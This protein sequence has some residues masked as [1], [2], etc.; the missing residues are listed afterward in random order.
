[1]ST[2]SSTQSVPSKLR[3]ILLEVISPHYHQDLAIENM[4]E[5]ELLV[6]TFGG[7]IVARSVQ[8]RTHPHPSTYI[9]PGKL[10]WLQQ[11]VKLLNA[12][13]V[14]L[15]SIVNSG[16]LFRLEKAIWQV[17]TR[18]QVWDRVDLILN[19]FDQ[20][21]T[22]LEAKLQIEF[23][24]IH[25]LGPRIYG[26]GATVF[27]RQGGGIGTRGLGE[28]NIERERRK[29]KDRKQV[30]SKRLRQLAGER[31]DVIAKRKREGIHTAALVGYTSAGK[32]TLFNTLTEKKKETNASLFTT[33]DTVVGKLRDQDNILISDTIGFIDD[34]PPYLIDAFR[35]TL[36]ESVEAQVLVHVIDAS[37][38]RLQ[39]KK[40]AVDTILKDLGVVQQPLLVFNKVDLISQEKRDK[41]QEEFQSETCFFISAKT[42]EGV[43]ALQ[44][45]LVTKLDTKNT[46]A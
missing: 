31:E 21:A 25:H 33:L 5:L 46:S 35:S 26:L 7:E 6:D 15:N 9:G 37:D 43:A 12:D 27:S 32:T 28:T 10:L 38:V 16:Q 42:R 4:E 13:V 2:P 36:L 23:A 14:V 1:M 20:H 3:F 17:N 19:I 8:H 34:L 40:H 39:E 22:S 30:I 45:Y 11:T 29:I 44:T 41:L 24:R 18:I